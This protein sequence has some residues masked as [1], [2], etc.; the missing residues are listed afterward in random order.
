MNEFDGS[1][2]DETIDALLRANPEII[3]PPDPERLRNLGVYPARD[4]AD[5]IVVISGRH[6]KQ[7]AKAT[8]SPADRPPG[9]RGAPVLAAVASCLAIGAILL[10]SLSDRESPIQV[11][12]QPA[13]P[14]MQALTTTPAQAERSTSD[15]AETESEREGVGGQPV[16]VEP[17]SSL[18]VGVDGNDPTPTPTSTVPR[19][20]PSASL[21]TAG[22]SPSPA[23]VTNTPKPAPTTQIVP[24]TTV[25]PTASPEPSSTSTA[26]PEATPTP[27]VSP[28]PSLTP[29]PTSTL[30][31]SPTP[32]PTPTVLPTPEV[33]V[34]A[35]VQ[36]IGCNYNDSY[37]GGSVGI[38]VPAF[39]EGQPMLGGQNLRE[40]AHVELRIF[41][42]EAGLSWDGTSWVPTFPSNFVPISGSWMFAVPELPTGTYCIA[43]AG[44]NINNNGSQWSTIG[45]AIEADDIPPIVAGE[46][47]RNTASL[48][49]YPPNGSTVYSSSEIAIRLNDDAN[50][51]RIL[52]NGT[53]V[54]LEGDVVAQLLSAER[55]LITLPP[56]SYVLESASN[57]GGIDVQVLTVR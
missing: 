34:G 21:I 28:E 9:L 3:P 1:E 10:F 32:S 52:N 20:T 51:F 19:A 7:R 46:G 44:R 42:I 13:A 15:A 38:D 33:F 4:S 47:T 48:I 26:T 16:E 2:L 12:T 17:N 22:T 53:E 40:A 57:T 49:R 29:T 14:T 55:T 24:T 11:A 30:E 39:S 37:G 23:A 50:S 27:S 45:F 41:Q 8:I 56:G 43:A 25:V 35:E 18:P 54:S 31:P 36:S 6:R 5:N